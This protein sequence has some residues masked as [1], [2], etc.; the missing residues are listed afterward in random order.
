M[1]IKLLKPCGLDWS[2]HKYQKRAIRFLLENQCAALFL[3]PGLGKTSI[4]LAAIKILKQ[5]K[6]IGKV[7]I[8]A[9]LRVCYS[10]WPREIEKWADFGHLTIEVLHGPD[11]DE[12][13]K[14]DADIY[15]TN[16][17]GLDWLLKSVK[18]KSEKSKKTSVNVNVTQFKKLG[19]DVLI[20]DELSKFKHI[21]TNRFKALKL[22]LHTF[23]RRWGLTGSP[24]A[25]GLL[26]LFGQAY[27][28]DLGRTFGPYITRYRNTYFQP[29][30]YKNPFDPEGEAQRGFGWVVRPG[31]E[32]EIYKRISPLAL[33]I[34]DS[35]LDMPEL[36]E[37]RIRVDLPENIQ[38]LYDQLEEE[39]ITAFEDRLVVANNAAAVSTKCR[40]IANGGVYY[41]PELEANGL[42]K[43]G[44]EFVNLHDAKTEALNELVEELQGQPLLVAYDFE[45]DVDRL[46]KAFPQGVFACDYTAKQFSDIE[47]AWNR[48]EIELLFGHPQSI[49]HG[50]N[51]QDC[52][53]HICWHSL[54]W[55][56][57]LYDQFIRRIFRQG[58]TSKKV[59]VHLIIARNTIDEVIV[60]ATRSKHK[61]QQALFHAIEELAKNKRRKKPVTKP[62]IVPGGAMVKVKKTVETSG[63]VLVDFSQH[64]VIELERTEDKVRYIPFDG[65][66]GLRILEMKIANFDKTYKPLPDYPVERAAKLYLSYAG[67]LG[68]T[69]EAMTHLGKFTKITQG[70]IAM[71]TNKTTPA[72]KEPAKKSSRKVE[73][74][75]KP[76][77]TAAK[78]SDKK[79]VKAATSDKKH[80]AAQMFK[81]LIMEGK[82]TDQQIFHKVQAEFN[83]D[84]SRAG[85][86]AWY[87]N[88]LQKSGHNP[89]PTKKEK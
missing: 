47:R 5:K 37:N 38:A 84:D 78:V 79:P 50:L 7:L 43:P 40:Q 24:A 46:K 45:H 15:V 2:P 20:I 3:D 16:P 4:T 72:K 39:L 62:I 49:G 14:R 75:T 64:T 48:G 18:T 54:T 77:K 41:F 86:V 12:A 23:S 60:G 65:E 26:D 67:H 29:K 66:N 32:D 57:E 42:V 17:E 36:V 13:L 55:N 9:P 61:G 76:T 35:E 52:G 89:P 25:N 19:F 88:N 58:N 1:Q 82:L 74:S 53:H 28:L 22:V 11:K 8:V 10:V 87:R 31:C 83:L 27:V 69:L 59:F 80:S 34:S 68:A 30:T 33:R 21:G 71:A 56:Y 81:D 70:E 63:R 51:L 44:R 73:E 85:Y 6:M